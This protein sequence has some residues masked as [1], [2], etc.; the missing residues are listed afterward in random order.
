PTNAPLT[1]ILVSQPSSGT[2]TLNADGSFT[3]TPDAG[4]TGTVTFTYYATDGTN[5]S[6]IATVTLDIESHFGGG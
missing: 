6:N 4:F 2:L 1:A 3:Y 5:D